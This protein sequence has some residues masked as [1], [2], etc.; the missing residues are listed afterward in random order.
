MAG[1]D[2]LCGVEQH[3]GAR[4]KLCIPRAFVMRP[5]HVVWGV[6]WTGQGQRPPRMV[7]L[8]MSEGQARVDQDARPGVWCG[9]GQDGA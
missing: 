7:S 6:K 5:R 9:Q 3:S 1:P 2:V 8:E 4:T